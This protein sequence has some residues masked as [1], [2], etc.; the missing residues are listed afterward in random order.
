MTELEPSPAYRSLAGGRFEL[1]SALGEGSIGA[2][3]RARHTGLG[4]IVAV[5]VL[6]EAFQRDV[7]FCRRFYAEALAMSRLDHPNLL[8][9]YDF[10]QE[11]DGLL[12][13]AMALAEGVTLR[14]VQAT[15][16]TFDVPRIASLMLQICAGLG[17]AHGRGLIHRD[18][19]PDNVMLVTQEDDDGNVVETVKV[20][21]FGFA[22]PPSVSADVAQRLAGTPV[23]MSPE[24]CLGEELDARSD[25]YACGIML[26]ELATGTVPFLSNDIEAIRQM[27][28][29]RTPPLVSATRPDIDPRF[30]LI[31]QRALAKSREDRQAGML[32]LRAE[33][34]TLLAR[35]SIPSS[36]RMSTLPERMSVP[37]FGPA[38]L[39]SV[40]PSVPTQPEF[41]TQPPDLSPSDWLETREEGYARHMEGTAPGEATADALAKDS[42]SV[43]GEIARHVS[44]AGSRRGLPDEATH[45]FEQRLAELEAAVRVLAQRG[46][47][48]TLQ[49]VASVVTGLLERADSGEAARS[50]LLPLARLF[51][52]GA[53]L[54]PLA[55]RILSGSDPAALELVL[56]AGTAGAHA[57][58]KARTTLANDLPA[59][60]RIAFVTTM[61]SFGPAALP[62]I[63]VALERLYEQSASGHHRAAVD[64]AEDLLL[65]VPKVE[66]DETGQVVVRFAGARAANLCRGAARAL[67][68]V[69][70]ARARAVLVHLVAHEDEGVSLAAVVGLHELELVD[71]EAVTSIAS[72][73]A[74]G[75]PRTPQLRAAFVAALRSANASARR[76]AAAV[77]ARLPA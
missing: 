36:M 13:I 57:L 74:A 47:A 34:K 22:V 40:R 12:Y 76:E 29:H 4:I 2:V 25:V 24:Q 39:P 58:Y 18:V 43:L 6:H 44:L 23:Y 33:L 15:E 59:P 46:D 62:L 38:P 45:L 52:D 69:W 54:V 61:K 48:R 42:S 71:L 70:G 9:V 11:S 5:K 28:V 77:L 10:G 56:R 31:V 72:R 75:H 55:A 49:R 68:R 3:Y 8:H 67:P 16:G 73:I 14:E 1:L 64:L 27:H 53:L 7:E 26:Y 51:V 35:E 21:D 50:A 63:R 65:G 32:E 41:E 19:K 37:S 66:D 60:A 20:L 17:H 30:E